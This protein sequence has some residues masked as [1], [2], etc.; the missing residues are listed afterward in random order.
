V[1]GDGGARGARARGR[2][3][4]ALGLGTAALGL[5]LEDGNAVEQPGGATLCQLG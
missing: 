3:R 1:L 2:R 4:S 5:G